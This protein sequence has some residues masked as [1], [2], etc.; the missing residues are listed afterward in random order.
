MQIQFF[1]ATKGVTGSKHMLRVNGKNVLLDCG[2]FQGHRVESIERNMHFPFDPA[3][4][5]VMVLS[6][7]HI[8]HSGA[9][10]SLVKNGFEGP[11]YCTH[12]TRDL[13]S[14]MLLDSG[15]IQEKDAEWMRKKLKDP[16]AEPIY[17]ME[18]A[19]RSLSQFRSVAYGQKIYITK[20]VH[21]TFHDAGHILGSA[22]EE[23]EIKDE[24][25]G[26]EIRLGFTGDLGRHDLPILNDPTPLKNLDALITES[27]YGNRLHDEI[28]AV[29]EQLA[30]TINQ[31][32]ERGGKVIIP[33]FAVERTQEILY[34][35]R[36]LIMA[37]KIPMMPVFVDSPLATRA[38]EIFRLHPECFD[39][40]L[41]E[42]IEKGKDPFAE[43][44]C[45]QFTRSVD[46]SKALNTFPDPCIIISASGMCEAGR[47]R[48]HLANMVS[49][50][51]N[52]V[53]VVGFMAANTLGRKLV[54]GESPVN[55]FGEPH[56]VNADVVIFNAF[57][58]HADQQD[59]LRYA[60]NAGELKNVFCVHGEESQIEVLQEELSKLPNCKN[61]DIYA[62][63]FETT[64]VL[65]ENK[66]FRER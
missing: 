7:A 15:Y 48:H 63:E 9:I 44:H 45:V 11:I 8:D 35:L 58:A 53:M 10:P 41:L 31:T 42:M 33:S 28:E 47:I 61:A 16:E 46:E 20:G 19:E 66:R 29:E 51:D 18:D 38:T 36:E 17:T 60:G 43:E 34:V 23:W 50:G 2:L 5:D 59:L 30:S 57:S 64:Y 39:K 4:V 37:K 40:E 56:D 55:I 49:N 52:T 22:V 27:T 65:G 6:H 12:A 14:V 21:V 25:T 26:Q 3:E 62:P 1:G 24:E 32:L 54:D 13:C